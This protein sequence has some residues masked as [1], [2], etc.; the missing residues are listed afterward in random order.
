[1]YF[2]RGIKLKKEKETKNTDTKSTEKADE[3][4]WY[5]DVKSNYFWVY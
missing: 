3:T 2:C 1:M 5:E 4:L